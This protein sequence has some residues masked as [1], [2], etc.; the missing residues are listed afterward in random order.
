M[1]DNHSE[2]YYTGDTSRTM[3]DTASAEG[4]A[5]LAQVQA[6]FSWA[7]YD[8]TFAV[9]T[10]VTHEV[11]DEPVVTF[12]L[13]KAVT[14]FLVGE[15]YPL[16]ARKFCMTSKKSFL[17]RYGLWTEAAPSYLPT[18]CTPMFKAT[19]VAEYNR[20]APDDIDGFYD[21]YFSGDPATVEAHF[22]LTERRGT[23]DTFY[24][25][26]LENGAVARVKQYVYNSS[27]MFSNWDVVHLMH[28]KLQR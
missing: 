20:P 17:K 10:P 7:N 5:I 11:L 22:E 24:G 6:E 28:T 12:V 16:S 14:T 4:L 15:A 2:I 25:V 9:S 21:C 3:H 26:T 13:N 8:G 18:G 19:N 27:T 1:T 23:Y